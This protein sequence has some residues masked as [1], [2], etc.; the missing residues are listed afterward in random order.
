[1]KIAYEAGHRMIGDGKVNENKREANPDD[2]RVSRTIQVPIRYDPYDERTLDLQECQVMMTEDAT[3]DFLDAFAVNDED[4]PGLAILDSGCTRTMHGTKWAKKFE[5][6]LMKIPLCPRLKQ[7]RQLF[8]GIGGDIESQ[9]VKVF[10]VGIGRRNGELHSAEVPGNNPMLISRPFMQKLGTIIN[11]GDGTVTFER[12]GVRDLPLRRT[13]KGHLAVSLLDFEAETV[14]IYDHLHENEEKIEGDTSDEECASGLQAVVDLPEPQQQPEQPPPQVQPQLRP[15]TKT[16]ASLP[17][18]PYPSPQDSDASW[19]RVSSTSR[20]ERASPTSSGAQR[21]ENEEVSPSPSYYEDGTYH[22]NSEIDRMDWEDQQDELQFWRMMA[23]EL[24]PRDRLSEGLICEDYEHFEKEIEEGHFT[25]RKPSNRKSKKISSMDISLEGED[26]L[27]YHILRGSKHHTVK[28]TPP[29]GKTWIK[30][31]Y[32]GAMGVTTLAVMFGMNIGVPLDI[33]ISGWNGGSATGKK[34]LHNDLMVEDPYCVIL[35]Q[36]CGPWGNWSRFNLAKGGPA[37]CTVHRLREEGR[38]VLKSVNKTIRD[39]VKGGR[40]VFMEQPLGSQSLDEPEMSDVKQMIQDGT[41][42]FIVVDGCMVGHKDK[43]SGLPHKK[44]SYYVTSL[45]CAESV[46]SG[47][48]CDGSH[49][50]Q[51]LEGNNKFGSRTFQAAEWP[52][53]LNKMVLD[54][55]IQQ[56]SVE[57]ES[58]RTVSEAYPA[59]VRPGEQPPRGERKAKRA[60]GRMSRVSTTQSAPP[61]YIRPDDP[62]SPQPQP[63]L[64]SLPPLDD[65]GFRAAQ[66]EELDPVLSMN[67]GERRH[68]WLKV[69]AELRKLLR[70]LHVQF[71][72]PTTTTLQRILRR[73]GAKAEVIK[74]ASLMS[75]DACGDTMRQKRPRPVKLPPRYQFNFHLQADV[76]YAKDNRGVNLGFL[77]IICDATSFQVVACLGEVSGTPASQVVLQHFLACWSSWAG[78]PH[79]LQ[80]DRGKEFMARFADY[81]KEFGVEHEAMPLEAPWKNGKCERAGGLWNEVWDKTV[82]DADIHTLQDAIVATSIVTQTRNSFPRSNGYAPNQWVLGV[83][84]VR[85]PGSLLD[86]DE[87]QQ[88]EVLEA[89]ENPSSAMAKNLAIRE[90]ARVAQIRLDTDSRVRRALLR[91]STPVRGPYPIGSYVY[92]YRRQVPRQVQEADSRNYNWYGP[93]RVIGVEL[94]NPRRLQDPEGTTSGAAPHSYWLR[95]GPSVVLASG[96]Q[97]RFASEDELLAAH[98]IPHYALERGSERGARNYVDVRNQLLTPQQLSGGGVDSDFWEVHPDRVV[99]VHY[100]ARKLLFSPVNQGCPVPLDELKSTRITEVIYGAEMRDHTLLDSLKDDWRSPE[101]HRELHAQWTGE[102]IFY[103]INNQTTTPS[104]LPHQPSS[105]PVIPE[106]EAEAVP[107]LEERTGDTPVAEDENEA[108]ETPFPDFLEGDEPME[109]QLSSAEPEPQPAASRAL[110]PRPSNPPIT[111]IPQTTTTTSTPSLGMAMAD[112]NRPVGSRGNRMMLGPYLVEQWQLDTENDWVEG[113]E[114]LGVSLKNRR[115]ERLLDDEEDDDEDGELP[116]EA[117]LENPHHEA[118]LTGKA[119]RSEVNLRDLNQA[120]RE[121]FDGS[122]AKE[123]ASFQKFNAV[124]VLSEK[125]IKELPNDVE[126]VSMRWVHTDKNQKPR[127]LAMAMSKKTGKSKKQIEKDYPFEAKSRMVVQGNQENNAGIRSDSP[128]GSLLAFNFVTAISVL[129]GW[130]IEA[131]DASTAYSNKG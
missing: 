20:E 102:T 33:E 98:Y 34:Q 39:R 89:A 116:E 46:F 11:I 25:V 100:K 114:D 76:F 99:R 74:A 38:S 125:Q 80:V 29:F 3:P 43:E 82:I 95:Y 37:A 88:L 68:E 19:E 93:A 111:S 52:A 55:V 120:D 41:L 49:E 81:L 66:A 28:R 94:R 115:L 23:A 113:C 63:S 31:I 7:K 10:P 22:R 21:N 18:Q 91:K 61:V 72:H 83:P 56:A 105:L 131:Y 51:P 50:H 60:R 71:G 108:A 101:A 30:Q 103:R 1:M 65:S 57:L 62:L 118:M 96:E 109:H 92:F 122:M 24:S 40:H 64:S 90:A 26:V 13:S 8:R 48:R 45:L 9:V 85:L 117:T 36:P 123:W 97:L 14:D 47:C 15:Q 87:S 124:E 127:L 77:N 126:I 119:V 128:T 2:M 73:Q 42:C 32:A 58:S 6:E 79:S 12:L 69:D 129:K 16:P 4:P 67:E 44:P 110:T 35:T 78:L 130:V 84:E 86:S 59:E 27:N 104:S 54:A 107:V 106:D 112:P 53:D 5:Q 17:P 75:C 70:D 121:K